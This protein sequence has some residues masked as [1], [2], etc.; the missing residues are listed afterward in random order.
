[1]PGDIAVQVETLR[2]LERDLAREWDLARGT[3]P[4]PEAR[5]SSLSWTVARYLFKLMAYKDEY[6]TA[7][8]FTDGRSRASWS[9]PSKA[10]TG[11][12]SIWRRL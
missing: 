7:R 11:W 1:M 6:E 4:G 12:S 9:G 8:L 3:G 10:T 2:T 5:P